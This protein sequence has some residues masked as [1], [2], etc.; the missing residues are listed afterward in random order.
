MFVLYYKKP[1]AIHD[2]KSG[3]VM[4]WR[5]KQIAMCKDRKPLQDYIDA[6]GVRKDL[7]YIEEFLE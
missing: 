4:T 3:Y 6:Q 5:G 1:H 7:Y 2:G